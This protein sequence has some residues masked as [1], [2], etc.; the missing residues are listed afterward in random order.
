MDPDRSLE[1]LPAMILLVMAADVRFVETVVDVL[2]SNTPEMRD[3]N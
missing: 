1:H 2:P 3:K